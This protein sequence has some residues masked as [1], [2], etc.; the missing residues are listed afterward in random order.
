MK[1][2]LLLFATCLALNW[3]SPLGAADVELQ[4]NQIQGV[5][6][7]S[8]V[9]P[10]ILSL[11]GPPGEE[12]VSSIYLTAQ[13]FPPVQRYASSDILTPL[14]RTEGSYQLNVDSTSGGIA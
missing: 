5:V 2:A 1:P 6:R 8:N 11:L 14:S 4:P 13:S 9:N 10:A 12:G 3:G 7:F